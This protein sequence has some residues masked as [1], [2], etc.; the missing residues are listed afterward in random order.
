MNGVWK[1]ENKN[2]R[3]MRGI[4]KGVAVALG[5][6]TIFLLTS[7]WALDLAAIR[8][9]M[10]TA[11][12]APEWYSPAWLTNSPFSP[13]F[14][15]LDTES[16]LGRY[17]PMGKR[18]TLKDLVKFHGHACDGL[19]QAACALR[20]ALDALFPAVPVDRT[21]LRAMSKNAPCFV[22]AVAYL[23]GGRIN[24]GTLEID[25]TLGPCWIIQRISTGKAV[26]VCL[27][28]GVFPSDL[29]ALEKKIKEGKAT[30]EEITRC[31]DMAFQFSKDLLT[32]PLAESF[33]VEAVAGFTFPESDYPR[34]G[35]RSDI[36]QKNHP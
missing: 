16:A 2:G 35:K 31:R 9:N 24:F 33:K 17:A 1:E 13:E 23:T 26:K 10:S 3:E 18:V 21:D 36:I 20:L 30:P 34:V 7:A 4:I 25:D 19:V 29:A 5:F 14:E 32:R 22:D 11:D 6:A 28:Q 12:R 27:R 15:L 8:V